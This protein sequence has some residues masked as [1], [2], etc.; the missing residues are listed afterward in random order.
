MDSIILNDLKKKLDRI[1]IEQSNHLLLEIENKL[2]NLT[3]IRENILFIRPFYLKKLDYD[4]ESMQNVAARYNLTIDNQEKDAVNIDKLKD[5]Q[6]DLD[7]YN[8]FMEDL[9]RKSN[10]SREEKYADQG[11]LGAIQNILSLSHLSL[12]DKQFSI[13]KLCLSND[14]N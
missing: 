1:D 8:Q 6:K 2:N 4:R 7:N 11:L 14:Q 5:L 12:K 13:E 9:E 3:S 10:L